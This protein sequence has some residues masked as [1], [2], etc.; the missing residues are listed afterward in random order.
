MVQA[1]QTKPNRRSVASGRTTIIR[2]AA[3][4]AHVYYTHSHYLGR[5]YGMVPVEFFS[6]FLADTTHN[7]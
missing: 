6:R 2:S 5:A 3:L 1:D 7:G 4:P